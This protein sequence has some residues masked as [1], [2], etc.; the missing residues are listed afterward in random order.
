MLGRQGRHLSLLQWRRDFDCASAFCEHGRCHHPR[1]GEVRTAR[2][3][4]RVNCGI[5][6]HSALGSTTDLHLYFLYAMLSMIRKSLWQGHVNFILRRRRDGAGLGMAAHPHGNRLRH[7]QAATPKRAPSFCCD[8]PLRSAT[9]LVHRHNN[10]SLVP[11]GDG[12]FWHL[13]YS[14]APFIAQ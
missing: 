10:A 11:G 6:G 8:H 14:L 7:V 13:A 12:L 4:N 1:V 9:A 5:P 3:S 2:V